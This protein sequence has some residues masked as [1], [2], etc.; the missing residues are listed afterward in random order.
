MEPKGTEMKF[1]GLPKCSK[2]Y[3]LYPMCVKMEA[4]GATMEQKNN[5]KCQRDTT[6]PCKVP[7]RPKQPKNMYIPP[8]AGCSPKAT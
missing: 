2:D 7:Q 8:A 1:Q 3:Q 5:P 4:Q 6:R